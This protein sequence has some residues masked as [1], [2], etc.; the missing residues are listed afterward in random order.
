MC[1]RVREAQQRESAL[2]VEVNEQARLLGMSAERECDLRGDLQNRRDLFKL[3]EHLMSELQDQLAAERTLA[4]RLADALLS[5]LSLWAMSP[6]SEEAAKS[7]AA[8]REVRGES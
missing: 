2:I 6:K 3:Q 5:T 4:D 7:I 1:K 8:W